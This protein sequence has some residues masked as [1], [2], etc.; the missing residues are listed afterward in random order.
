MRN[1]SSYPLNNVFQIRNLSSSLLFNQMTRPILKTLYFKI[2]IIIS[3]MNCT[4]LAFIASIFINTFHCFLKQHLIF[5]FYHNNSQSGH[6]YFHKHFI[7]SKD[8]VLAMTYNGFVSHNGNPLIYDKFFVIFSKHFI[9]KHFT[10][11][12][13]T[14]EALDK[15]SH[16]HFSQFGHT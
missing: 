4:I 1:L 3:L 5:C 2:I 13:Y 7:F 15:Q 8:I 10:S 6:P 16:F 11:T 9:V 12:L 14:S